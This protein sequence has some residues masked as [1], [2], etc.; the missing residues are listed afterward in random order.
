MTTNDYDDVIDFIPMSVNG[1]V[2]YISA[3]RESDDPI[4]CLIPV[5]LGVMGKQL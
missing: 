1:K 2:R 3:P 5:C 4:E